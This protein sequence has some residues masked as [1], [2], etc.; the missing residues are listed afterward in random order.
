MLKKNN[1]SNNITKN[2]K[3]TKTNDFDNLISKKID[4]F[5]DI[6]QKTILYIQQNTGYFRCK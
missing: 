1:N 5:K 3:E 2:T 4:F 6:I